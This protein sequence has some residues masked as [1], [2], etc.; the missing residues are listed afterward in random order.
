MPIWNAAAKHLVTELAIPLAT[1]GAVCVALLV[2]EAYWLLPSTMLVFYGL[3]LFGAGRYAV[4]EVRLLG[5]TQLTLGVLAAFLD[6]QG[7][8][9]WTLGFGVCHI[10]FGLRIYFAYER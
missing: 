1:G 3:A 6:A 7:L 2:R 8:N 10:V 5:L 4:S 9:L